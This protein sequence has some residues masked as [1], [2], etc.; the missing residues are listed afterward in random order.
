MIGLFNARCE[1]CWEVKSC[2]ARVILLPER[3]H[4]VLCQ[5]CRFKCTD[6]YALHPRHQEF[7]P[8]DLGEYLGQDGG[9]QDA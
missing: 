2:C 3:H 1:D 9:Q 7:P 5:E 8:R 6:K 4:V